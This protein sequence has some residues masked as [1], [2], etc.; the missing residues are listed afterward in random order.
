MADY[1]SEVFV[2]YV[3]TVFTSAVVK[4]FMWLTASVYSETGILV[5]S[6]GFL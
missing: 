1:C 2:I 3:P 6:S 5:D 4:P